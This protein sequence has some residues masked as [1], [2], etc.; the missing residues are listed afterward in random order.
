M[1]PAITSPLNQQQVHQWHSAFLQLNQSR[2]EVARSLMTSRQQIVLDVLPLLLHFNHP[3]M[4]GFISHS[5][6]C[7]VAHY[8]AT[9]Q[10]LQSLQ[11]VARGVQAPRGF[12][13][14]QISG[15]Y[16]IGSVGSLAQARSSDMDVWLCYDE[17]LSTDELAG[18]QR[19]CELIEQ[20]AGGMNVELHFFLMNLTEFRH[21]QSQSAQGEDCGSTQHL[22]LLDEFYRSSLW[23]AGRQPR[24]WLIPNAEE[25]SAEAFWQAL[26]VNHRVNA[27]HWL[28]F[29]AMPGIPPS[30]FVGAGLWQLNKGLKD[31]Y[32][33]LLKLLITRHYAGQYPNIR[34]LCW[35][36]KDQVHR[37]QM[38]A[39]SNDAY[40]LM[41]SRLTRQ[42]QQEG[43]SE[44]VQ[45]ARRAFYYKAGIPLSE[46]SRNQRNS[47]RAQTMLNLCHS[48]G[49]HDEQLQ[50]LDQRPHW[51]PLRIARERNALI[52]EM[53]GSYR[54]LA[55][56]SQKYAPRLHISRADMQTL[57]NRLH[58]AFDTRPGK[59]IDIN[60]GIS[61]AIGQE[62]L[63]LNRHRDTWQLIPGVFY[64]SD[65]GMREQ[66]QVLKQSPSLVELLCFAR[67]NGLL[68]NYTRMA[69]YPTHNP[70]SQYELK[71]VTQ[72][73]R[74]LKPYK[75]ENADFMQ[76][77]RPLSWHLLVNVGVDP[78]Y[79]LSRRGMQKISNRDD[80]LGYS[81]ARENLVLT[82]DLVS[83]NSWGEWLVERFTGDAAML[84]CLQNILQYL[85]IARTNGWPP[86]SVHCYCA[87]RASAIRLRVEQLLEDVQQH[88]IRQP[89]APYLIEAAD[90]WYL[91]ENSRKGIR[92]RIA[93][94]PLK[95]LALLA[96]PATQFIGYTLDRTA[97]LS[98]P[99]RHIFA[100]AKPGL[101]QLFYWRKEGRLY[102]YFLDEKGALLH[103]QWPDSAQGS[104]HW[105][106]PQLRF[107]RQADQRWQVHDGRTQ[108]RKIML[109]EL[110]RK[111]QTY[112]FEL[113]RRKIPDLP[114]QNSTIDLRAVLDSHQQATLYCDGMEFSPWQYGSELYREVVNEV[115]QRRGS[116]EHYPL[117]LSDV[118]LP[119][120]QNMIEHLQIK[121]R[122]ENRL[123]Q[124]LKD[125][126]ISASA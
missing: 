112:D 42:L 98:S 73:I 17:S 27:D 96:R 111:A 39:E 11:T 49:W 123:M 60:P 69:V 44:R 59:I 124:A 95:L 114:E 52:S 101:W 82:I 23:L 103:Q 16:L 24:W 92:L 63:A 76:P 70:L 34:P 109:Y 3:Q 119:D 105:L 113:I 4:P 93:D 104:Q 126:K 56:F 84:Q 40:L 46:L 81:A 125:M 115:L 36:L 30:E 10:Q 62:R 20:W 71:E 110:R 2:L 67:C 14:Q 43:N 108:L 106:L 107:L 120:S 31:P 74:A 5:V 53:L 50:E 68:E 65:D 22:L 57:G 18:L 25:R 72:V 12:A 85:P 83:I 15:V 89:K 99:L 61:P 97:L 102:F 87:S 9:A 117:F 122:L 75:P 91:L 64:R 29:G 54:F 45:L 66:Q 19:K 8:S 48:W 86:L 79:E 90:S 51:S 21:G 28:D 55:A 118:E 35:D 100:Q 47:W 58:A 1:T 26:L 88:F 37:G 94:S 116:H 38:D 121:Q 32:K 78:Q 6:P 80:A 13:Q 77:A 7:G 33:S 41:L